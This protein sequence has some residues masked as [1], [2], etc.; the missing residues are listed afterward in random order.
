MYLYF[1]VYIYWNLFSCSA[2]IATP[3]ELLKGMLF[4]FT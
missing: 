4:L 3:F 1:V 2:V